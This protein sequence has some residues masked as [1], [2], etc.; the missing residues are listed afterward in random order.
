MVERKTLLS[1]AIDIPVWLEQDRSNAWQTRVQR[2]QQIASQSGILFQQPYQRVLHWW[3]QIQPKTD[4]QSSGQE[5]AS[6]FKRVSWIVILIGFFTGL[7]LASALLYYDGSQPINVLVL[8]IFLVLLPLLLFFVSLILPLLNSNSVVSGLNAGSMVFSFLK[9][10]SPVLEAFFSSSRSDAAKDKLLRWRLLLYSQQFGM[11]LAIAA[12]LTLLARVS[13]SDLAFGWSTTLDIEASTLSPWVQAL[14]WPWVTWFPEAVP[15]TSLIEQSRY[16]RL[17]NGTSELSAQTLTGWWKFIAMCLLVYGIGF[18]VLATWVA[19][20][21]YKKAIQE[22]LMQHSEVTALLD[23]FDAPIGSGQEQ[24]P[25]VSA[26]RQT[27]TSAS[28]F[29]FQSADAIILWNSARSSNKDLQHKNIIEVSGDGD[30]QIDSEVIRQID[31]N[32][33]GKI[34]IIT[35]AWEPP[36]LEF[37]DFIQILRTKFGSEVSISIQPI[38]ANNELPDATDVE[39]WRHSIEKL[40]DPKVYVI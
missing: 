4:A 9:K 1:N 16:F 17:A 26:E 33:T 21:N 29:D 34:H 31:V 27:T 23:R 32:E 25:I 37:H 40:Q 5:L 39:I 15:S 24:A 36:L 18:R 35:K 12:L 28:T 7:A 38:S 10:K 13:F 30:L 6:F 11:A 22:M 8:L 14:A 20:F 3:R 2:D 19:N